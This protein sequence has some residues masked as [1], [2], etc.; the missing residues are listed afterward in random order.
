MKEIEVT[1]VIC[2]PFEWIDKTPGGSNLGRAEFQVCIKFKKGEVSEFW[3]YPR[4]QRDKKE[5]WHKIYP[6][7]KFFAIQSYEGLDAPNVWLVSWCADHKT[8]TLSI[9]APT[10]SKYLR[11]SYYGIAFTKTLW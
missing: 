7:D 9:Y 8:Q 1:D 4:Q 6:C 11:I 10:D 2:T 5:Y 3:V